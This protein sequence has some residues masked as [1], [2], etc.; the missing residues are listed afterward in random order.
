[1]LGAGIVIIQPS[2]GK[3]VLVDD[4]VHWFLPK[5]RKDRGESLEQTALREGYEESGYRCEFLPLFS[6][7]RAPMPPT[8]ARTSQKV[9]EP[10]FTSI[11]AWGPRKIKDGAGTYTDP[12]GEYLTFWYVGQIGPDAV[13]EENTGMPDETTYT[14]HLTTYEE[15][16][17]RLKNAIERHI[18][19]TAWNTWRETI[20]LD[21]EHEGAQ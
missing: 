19:N 17:S 20:A 11:A 4:G 2:T 1:M 13:R 18:V 10:L 5:G 21:S 6:Y 3:I 7:S 8:M 9:T 14:G 16:M 15:A 12:G